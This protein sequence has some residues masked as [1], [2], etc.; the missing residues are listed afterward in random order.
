MEPW[1]PTDRRIGRSAAIAVV[2]IAA[3]YITT[4]TVWLASNFNSVTISTL[5][6]SEPYLTIM[7]VLMLLLNPALIALFAVLHVYAPPGKKTYSLAAF[8]F[9]I[10]LVAITSVVH[11]INLTVNRRTTSTTVAEAFAFYH[12]QPNQISPM[13]AAE[14]LGWD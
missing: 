1:T 5:A 2:A 14:M 11:F 6:P 3:V 12:S 4:G 9:V 13:F 7:E 10:L 8:S